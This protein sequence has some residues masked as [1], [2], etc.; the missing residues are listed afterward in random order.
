[1]LT[2]FR[3]FIEDNKEEIEALKVLYSQPYRAG[4]RFRHVKELAARLNQP[5]FYVDPDHPETLGRLWQ[6][7]EVGRAE[8]GPGQ[9]GQATG[10]RDRPSSPRHRSELDSGP[11][12]L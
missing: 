5:P 12:R 10:G 2:S 7:Y 1:M 11:S 6:A 3:Q 4:L 8:E 9:R